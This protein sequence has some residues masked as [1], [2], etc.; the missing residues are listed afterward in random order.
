MQSSADGGGRT[1]F[2]RDLDHENDIDRDIDVTQGRHRS[3]QVV[4]EK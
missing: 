4:A 2:L 1:G 3:R